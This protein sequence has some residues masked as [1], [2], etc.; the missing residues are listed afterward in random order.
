MQQLQEIKP[1]IYF[2]TSIGLFH[3]ANKTAK[4]PLRVSSSIYAVIRVIFCYSYAILS[5][6]SAIHD[7]EDISQTIHN[8]GHVVLRATD[9]SILFYVCCAKKGIFRFIDL[10][11]QYRLTKPR[12][13]A[14]YKSSWVLLILAILHALP[15]C[16]YVN[17][18][19]TQNQIDS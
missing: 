1:V 13:S 8:T 7:H 16:V 15:I 14:I 3:F 6:F 12:D 2:L 19:R 5:L 10:W 17:T 9:I 11:N 18:Q 4:K